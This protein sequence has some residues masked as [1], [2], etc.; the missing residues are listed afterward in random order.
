MF[1]SVPYIIDNYDT[2]L[3]IQ[4]RRIE[5][6]VITH[7]V[8]SGIFVSYVFYEGFRRRQIFYFSSTFSIIGIALI[9]LGSVV[10]V[11]YHE[12]NEVRV[13]YSSNITPYEARHDNGS[14]KLIS[15]PPNSSVMYVWNDYGRENTSI[16]QFEIGTTGPV[17]YSVSELEWGR[18]P[19]TNQIIQN[20]RQI[21]FKRT[22]FGT[23]PP[24]D[25]F[26]HFW[27]TPHSSSN[28][29]G[30]ELENSNDYDITVSMRITELFLKTTDQVREVYYDTLLESSFAYGG[31][32]L[33]G[34][35]V[36]LTTLWW[37]KERRNNLAPMNL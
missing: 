3:I 33:L 27:T 1:I 19:Q 23:G 7:L 12:F 35:S 24:L 4:Q 18:D 2:P 17:S 22:V 30:F 11:P 29:K 15:I 21:F 26:T 6:Y 36:I 8:L 25:W 10:Q 9:F 28:E 16:I 14:S 13:D 5:L 34:V 20:I 32:V 37:P 31:L